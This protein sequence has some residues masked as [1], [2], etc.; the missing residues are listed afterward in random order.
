MLVYNKYRS[1]AQD[2]LEGWGNEGDSEQKR[3]EK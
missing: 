1:R 2:I 3:K